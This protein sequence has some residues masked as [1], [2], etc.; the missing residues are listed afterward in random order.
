MTPERNFQFAIIKYLDQSRDDLASL[1]PEEDIST[2]E[3]KFLLT[4]VDSI[5]SKLEQSLYDQL[6]DHIYK[7]RST[8]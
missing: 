6:H 2:D 1:D 7:Y 8:N 3:H 4:K 5:A